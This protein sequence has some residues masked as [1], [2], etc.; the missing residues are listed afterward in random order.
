MSKLEE[1][2]LNVPS[3]LKNRV[4]SLEEKLGKNGP[5]HIDISLIS[6]MEKEQAV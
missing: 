1:D 5:L 6:K 2:L 4:E 3:C